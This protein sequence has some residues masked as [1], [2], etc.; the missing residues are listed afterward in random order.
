MTRDETIALWQRCE[1]ARTAAIAEGKTE[2]EAHEAA[3]EIWNGWANVLLAKRKALVS[4]RSWNSRYYEDP[5]NYGEREYGGNEETPEWLQEATCDFSELQ[6]GGENSGEAEVGGTASFASRGGNQIR[7]IPNFDGYIFPGDAEFRSTGFLGPSSFAGTVFH[8]IAGFRGTAFSNGVWFTRADFKQAA[9]FAQ[10]KFAGL[11]D[12]D[13]ATFRGWARFAGARFEQLANFEAAKFV[14]RAWFRG[15]VFSKRGLFD[16]AVFEGEADFSGSFF[17]QSFEM[18]SAYFSAAPSFSQT[19]FNEIPDFEDVAFRLP[20]MWFG[21]KIEEAGNYRHIRRL[22]MQGQD[23]ENEAK[24]FKGE[25]RS[26]RGTTH[27]WYQAAFWSG[28]TYDALSDFGQSI[29][30]PLFF[31]VTSVIAFAGAY[32]WSAGVPADRWLGP[33]SAGQASTAVIALTFSASNSLPLIGPPR[34]GEGKA[35]VDCVSPNQIPDWAALVQ[36]GQ[37]MWSTVL[38]FLFLLAVRNQF[39]IK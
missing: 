5:S 10:T 4:K 15:C 19:S 36:V 37:A 18:R 13:E 28:V 25:I 39:R 21:H 16:K 12:F 23:Y 34:T 3:K 2:E 27:K 26:K 24:A 17:E 11:A 8:G 33:C 7:R 20:G 30:R 1:E 35:F 22:A 32:L 38:V 6:F 14:K 29:S 31:W 9:W